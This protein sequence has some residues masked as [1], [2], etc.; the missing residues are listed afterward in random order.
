MNNVDTAITLEKKKDWDY[1][2]CINY[3]SID[4]NPVID[5]R[6][7]EICDKENQGQP[8]YRFVKRRR[9]LLRSAGLYED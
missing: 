3:W 2:N 5:Q 4:L 9:F 6:N 7:V 1:C 8:K